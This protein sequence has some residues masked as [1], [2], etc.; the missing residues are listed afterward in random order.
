M[1]ISSGSVLV[2]QNLKFCWK[3]TGSELVLTQAP[4]ALLQLDSNP[5]SELNVPVPLPRMH[6]V[7]EAKQ[8]QDQTA[9]LDPEGGV[10]EWDA[11]LAS[12]SK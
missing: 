8:N 2:G 5:T 4:V 12:T 10:C 7:L 11:G 6:L 9:R 1:L 3:L